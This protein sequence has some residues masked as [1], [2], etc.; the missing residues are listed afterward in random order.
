MDL[1]EQNPQF[2]YIQAPE[3]S[4]S[5]FSKLIKLNH[6]DQVHNIHEQKPIDQFQK[7][8]LESSKISILHKFKNLLKNQEFMHE[9]KCK[10]KGIMD[11][12]ALGEENLTK[13]KKRTKTT[14]N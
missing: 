11:L 9:I 14:K 1:I 8:W 10:K 3:I 6:Q 5:Q 7:I 4:I 2:G 13:K 12:L